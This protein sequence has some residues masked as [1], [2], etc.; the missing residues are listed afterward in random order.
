MKRRSIATAFG[1]LAMAVSTFLIFTGNKMMV[2]QRSQIAAKSVSSSQNPGPGMAIA[3]LGAIGIGAS[4]LI[5]ARLYPSR[6]SQPANTTI[7]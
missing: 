7:E 1:V 4:G 5:F 3:L 2:A 6:R